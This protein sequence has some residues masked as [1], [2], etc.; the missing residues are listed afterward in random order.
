MAFALA[1][2]AFVCAFV[3]CVDGS[4]DSQSSPL[5]LGSTVSQT[6]R[7]RVHDHGGVEV[8]I[9]ISYHFSQNSQVPNSYKSILP[10]SSGQTLS[11]GSVSLKNQYGYTLPFNYSVKDGWHRVDYS[12][13][14]ARSS[15]Y[16]VQ[17][18]YSISQGFCRTPTGQLRLDMEWA[19]HWHV[20]VN[21]SR[22]EITFVGQN[23]DFAFNNTCFL[24]LGWKPLCGR[25][26]LVYNLNRAVATTRGEPSRAFF[27]W[28]DGLTKD[29]QNSKP[30]DSTRLCSKY[31]EVYGASEETGES[32]TIIFV[33]GGAFVC[34]SVCACVFCC[35]C[36]RCISSACAKSRTNSAQ[37]STSAKSSKIKTNPSTKSTTKQTRPSASR[38]PNAS[39][40]DLEQGGPTLLKS[41]SQKETK[42]QFVDMRDKGKKHLSVENPDP[43]RVGKPQAT[44]GNGPKA[45]KGNVQPTKEG[46]SLGSDRNSAALANAECSNQQHITP[47]WIAESK[48]PL[49]K[50][51]KEHRTGSSSH[52][53]L[54]SD[55]KQVAISDAECSESMIAVEM[56]PEEQMI[57]DIQAAIDLSLREQQFEQHIGS[58]ANDETDACA[59][60]LEVEVKEQEPAV[61]EISSHIAQTSEAIEATSHAAHHHRLDK[62]VPEQ[63]STSDQVGSRDAKL[64]DIETKSAS[65]LEARINSGEISARTGVSGQE[66]EAQLLRVRKLSEAGEERQLP[67]TASSQDLR[68]LASG[69]DL[70]TQVSRVNRKSE[71]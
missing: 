68:S 50:D 5:N 42:T 16:T 70:E 13:K 9:S 4:Y 44:S 30:K 54:D 53:A 12:V 36:A 56:N 7:L 19:H 29:W 32:Q 20:P 24:S 71:L 62:A 48:A 59:I 67:S 52:T 15:E 2:C 22:Y 35:L 17:L 28:V 63:K 61:H 23:R 38:Q 8:A 18:E 14:D 33:I 69:Q 43:M 26:E 51:L 1:W 34:G 64:G 37:K 6:N 57:S 49:E 45:V 31:I 47:S 65:L 46:S 55:A 60:M 3:G 39:L 58:R 40:P 10:T 25:G 27:Q 66:L 11:N 41:P 21:E